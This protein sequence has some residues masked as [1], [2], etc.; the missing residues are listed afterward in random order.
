MKECDVKKNDI[1][2]VTFLDVRGSGGGAAA[3][4]DIVDR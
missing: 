2:I 3:A 4:V 1:S